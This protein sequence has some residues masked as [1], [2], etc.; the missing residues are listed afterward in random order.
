M[1]IKGPNLIK[2][3]R[4]EGLRVIG[5]PQHFARHYY[6]SGIDE[7]LYVDTVASLYGRNSLNDL[8]DFTAQ[9]IFI[10]ITVCGGIRSVEDVHLLLRAGA[11]KVAINT[12]AVKRPSL[13]EDVA[14]A[15]G[16]QCMV[17]SIE[18]KSV[19]GGRWEVY[20]DNGRE[21]SGQDAVEWA[22]KAEKLGAGEILVT[23][24]DHD[25]TRKGFDVGLI[26]AI[27]SVVGIP[28]IA[29]GG[30]GKPSH[31]IELAN[32]Y[33]ISA[34]AAGSALHYGNTTVLEIKRALAAN[35]IE[36]RMSPSG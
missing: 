31:L 18:A 6:E 13:V 20:T 32:K 5:S 22:M 34:V 21:H 26:G 24:V 23:S 7:L 27:V 8:L 10:P 33:P 12:A 28:V 35:G 16:S 36:C 2:G 25:G 14:R 17:L 1:D 29:G 3:I 15:F 4:F 19:G 9:N 30:M 11:D